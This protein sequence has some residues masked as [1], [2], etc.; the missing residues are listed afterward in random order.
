MRIETVPSDRMQL[1]HL[2]DRHLRPAVLSGN[3]GKKPAFS[4]I[5][6]VL[7]IGFVAGLACRCGTVERESESPECCE[8]CQDSQGQ[9]DERDEAAPVDVGPHLQEGFEV[10]KYGTDDVGD[11]VF[12]VNTPSS[13]PLVVGHWHTCAIVADLVWCWGLN[14]YGQLGDEYLADSSSTP[15]PIAEL[16]GVVSLTS[17]TN[18]VCAVKNS[19]TVWCWGSNVFGQLGT[20]TN[21]L[22]A[23]T[24]ILV[25]GLVDV[26]AVSAGVDHTCALKQD[27]TAWCW[28]FN[29]YAQLGIGSTNGYI[30]TEVKNPTQVSSIKEVIELSAHGMYTC[31]IQ[32]NQAVWCWGDNVVSSKDYSQAD[33]GGS[34]P[35][36]IGTLVDVV[37]LAGTCAIK[38]DGGVWCW[39]GSPISL[40]SALDGATY[41]DNAV[42]QS[43]PGL[44]NI[45][46][47]TSARLF[48]LKKDGTVWCWECEDVYAFGGQGKGASLTQ[49]DGLTSATHIAA[50]GNH[51]CTMLQT[52]EI[53][54]WGD[55]SYGQLGDGT[56]EP[57]SVPTFVNFEG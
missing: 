32:K 30:P 43:I 19:G 3:R 41:W 50:N 57:K 8:V 16:A 26:A 31:A 34:T 25:D 10:P 13:V 6:V 42:P 14:N 1:G 48:A 9:P 53:L 47:L 55:N 24:P 15:T 49:I 38:E 33:V 27:G 45:L 5:A 7:L 36:A 46:A 23:G 22:S 28:G 37:S 29:M 39:N 4:Q 18:H 51:A 40:E 2:A 54:C 11:A 17:G 52:G 35:V 21:A 56:T 44:E 20:G 12:A